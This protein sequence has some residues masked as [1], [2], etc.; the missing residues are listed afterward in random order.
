VI[1]CNLQRL[2]G[3]VR[4]NGNIIQELEGVFRGAGWNVIKVIWGSDWDPLFAADTDGL[5]I[6]H[7]GQIV[8]GEWQRYTVESGLVCPRALLR[9]RPGPGPAGRSPDRRRDPQ[10]SGWAGTIR[11]RSTRRTRRRWHEGGRR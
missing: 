11:R 9:T 6:E 4:G 10:R 7:M 2:D 3:P 5:L 8:D 1:N